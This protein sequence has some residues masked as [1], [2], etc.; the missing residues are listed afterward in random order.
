MDVEIT[1]FI[2]KCISHSTSKS[3]SFPWG[4]YKCSADGFFL[5]K[6]PNVAVSTKY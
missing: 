3:T 4:S 5:H 1:K 6:S 2:L